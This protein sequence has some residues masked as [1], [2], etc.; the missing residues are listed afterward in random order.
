MSNRLDNFRYQIYLQVHTPPRGEEARNTATPIALENVL[1]ATFEV[2][3]IYTAKT[4]LL[5]VDCV[6]PF[7][8]YP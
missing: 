3:H 2:T 8:F 6:T 5:A 4:H 7:A 1:S